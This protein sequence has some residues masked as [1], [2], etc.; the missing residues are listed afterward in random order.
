[1]FISRIE[2]YFLEKF[3]DSPFILRSKTRVFMYLSFTII[4]LMLALSPIFF[5]FLPD[6]AIQGN[7]AI[8]TAIITMIMGL[9]LL[10]RGKYQIASN[11]V[12]VFV[13]LIL[14]G[15]L[16]AKVNRDAY[17]GYTTYIYLMI[18]LQVMISFLCEKRWFIGLTIAFV[19]SD[20]LFFFLAR[21]NLDALS[22]K[23]ARVGMIDSAFALVFSCISL[24]LL[25]RT[26]TLAVILTEKETRK[27]NEHSK[28]IGNLLNS[29]KDTSVKLVASSTELS[30]TASSFSD[31]AQGQASSTEEIM[32]TVEEVSAGVESIACRTGNQFEGLA[33]LVGKIDELSEIINRMS[34]RVRETVSVTDSISKQAIAGGDSLKSMEASIVKISNSSEEMTDIVGI[35]NDISDQINLLSLNA[36][37]EAARAG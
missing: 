15:G 35:I 9:T 33:S 21:T 25:N 31:N 17:R 30:S 1:M 14:I 19:A 11:L 20:V 4:I 36:S 13:S 37:I 12:M 7:I 18:A 8:Y 2:N 16:L 26:A 27:A 34:E 32:A 5:F 3:V 28:V 6:M 22:Y 23:A 29:L 24:I 10:R